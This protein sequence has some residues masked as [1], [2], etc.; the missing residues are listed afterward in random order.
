MGKLYSALN[1]EEK[2]STSVF[3]FL[4]LSVFLGI[5]YGAFDVGAHALF[6]SVYPAEM[7]PKAYVISGVAGIILTSLY[8]RIQNSIPF[9]RLAWINLVF[10]S[11]STA[12]LRILFQFTESSW[13]IFLI[14]VMMGPLNIIAMLGFWGAAGRMFTL[15]QGKR[16]FG[17]IDSG[18]IF[19]A[20]LS[21]FAIPVLITFGFQQKNLLFLSSVSIIGALFVQII[22]SIKYNLNKEQAVSDSE[23]KTFK[24][25]FKSKYIVYMAIF[26]VMSM[27][28]AFFIQY[29]FLSVTKENYPDHNDLTEFLGAF[30]GSLLLF[31]FLFK[32]F[33]YS[34]LMKTYGLKF[35]ITVSSFLLG[36]FTIIAVLIGTFGGYTAAANGFV[37]FFLIISLSRLFSKALKDAVEV[38]S[39]KILYQSLKAD[40]RHSVQAYVDGTINEIAALSAGLMLAVL[41]LFEFF[42]LIHF[43]YSLIIILIIWSFIARKLYVEYKRSLQESL[44]EY[45]GSKDSKSKLTDFVYNIDLSN[46]SKLIS[47]LEIES[48]LRPVLFEENLVNLLNS[49]QKEIKTFVGNKIASAKL[50]SFYEGLMT[51]IK[52]FDFIEKDNK[53]YHQLIKIDKSPGI[54]K[55]IQL[56]KSKSNDERI[57]A[58]FLIGKFYSPDLFIYLKALIR[59]LNIQVKISAIRAAAQTK[60]PEFC[61]LIIDYLDTPEVFAYSYDTIIDFGE[62]SLVYLD[63]IFYKSGT[64]HR[65]LLRIIKLIGEIGGNKAKEILL[66]KLDHPNEE[67]LFYILQALKNSGFN[68]DETNIHHINQIIEKQIGIIGWNIAAKVTVNEQNEFEYL[69]EA[70]EEELSSNFDLLYLLLS[71]AYDSKSIMHVKENLE[72]GTTEGIGY[73]LELLDLFISDELKPKLFPVL[74]DIQDIE[75]VRQLQNFYAI[76]KLTIE[77]LLIDIINRDVNNINI[78]TKACA[79]Q[80]ILDSNIKNIPD[81]LIAHVFNPIEFLRESALIA[82][83]TIQNDAYEKLKNRIEDYHIDESDSMVDLIDKPKGSLIFN[84]TIIIKSIDYFKSAHGRYIYHLASKMNEYTSENADYSNIIISDLLDKIIIIHG[85]DLKLIIEDKREIVLKANEMYIMSEVIESNVKNLSIKGENSTIYY[86]QKHDL[87][88]NMFDYYDIEKSIIKWY[89]KNVEL[90]ENDS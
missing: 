13:L 24:D 60:V 21:A 5:F 63:Q 52:D 53:Q 18:Q 56:T 23:K 14:F 39:F 41:G 4:T 8:A 83:N 27:L 80:A 44:A 3:L 25:I 67:I 90:K 61:P 36:I 68:A 89:N 88:Y 9:S 66:K 38:P 78:W 7:I 51:K 72:S 2:E 17:L 86:I 20:I 31:T 12:L 26:V 84:K 85:D 29:S 15:R 58:A 81:D 79:I 70:I 87:I 65:V 59:D 46:K 30:T 71:L 54:E 33:V 64:N 49:E 69:K 28:A 77:N 42:T 57:L 45:K 19:G 48:S 82:V 22:I 73:A 1:I 40:I 75:R 34:K 43:S 62:E 76:E 35:S 37:F 16:L 6:L 47:G 55:L 10:I 11:L 50:I 74:E 32:T